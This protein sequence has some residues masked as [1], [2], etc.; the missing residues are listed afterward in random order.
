MLSDPNIQANLAAVAETVKLRLE[1]V[2]GRT[3]TKLAE[4]NPTIANSLEP[5]LPNPES[6]KWADVFKSVSI[7]GD[8]DIPINKRGSG[9]KRLVLISFFRAEAERRPAEA[10]FSSIVYAIEEPEPSQHPEH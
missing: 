6:L 9:V 5:R 7:S 8:E 2:A 1:Q 10:T 3:L 4:L